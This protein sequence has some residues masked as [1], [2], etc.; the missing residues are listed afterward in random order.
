MTSG[1]LCLNAIR[2]IE[3]G[4]GFLAQSADGGKPR[5]SCVLHRDGLRFLLRFQLLLSE[6]AVYLLNKHMEFL[7]VLLDCSKGTELNHAV[8]DCIIHMQ[9][10]FSV[11][12]FDGQ[13]QKLKEVYQYPL[14]FQAKKESTLVPNLRISDGGLFL[15]S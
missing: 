9:P 1:V 12:V 11:D 15:L 4:G 6:Q 8:V 7:G 5:T 2:I 14:G 13:E 3:M 10:R